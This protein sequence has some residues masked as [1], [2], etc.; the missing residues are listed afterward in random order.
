MTEADGLRMWYVALP[1]AWP[2]LLA[3]AALELECLDS[4]LLVLS[5]AARGLFAVNMGAIRAD[6][7]EDGFVLGVGGFTSLGL[8]IIA[9]MG[10]AFRPQRVSGGAAGSSAERLRTLNRNA[11]VPPKMLELRSGAS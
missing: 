2:E 4:L 5:G 1:W 9:E 11:C 8:F 3:K 7:L 6:W 10:D